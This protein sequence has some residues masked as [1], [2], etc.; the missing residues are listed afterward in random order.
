[1]KRMVISCLC[2]V[3]L[4]GLG[5]VLLL[6]GGWGPCGPASPVGLLGGILALPGVFIAG[7]NSELLSIAAASA[8]VWSLATFMI[9]TFAAFLRG[10]PAKGTTPASGEKDLQ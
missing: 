8:A 4:S 5:L 2:G 6:V 3:V 1:M 7:N 9:L 10:P